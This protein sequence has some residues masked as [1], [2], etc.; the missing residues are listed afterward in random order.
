MNGSQH[1]FDSSTIA[2]APSTISSA[3]ANLNNSADNLCSEMANLM[4]DYEIVSRINVIVMNHYEEMNSDVTKRVLNSI[5][6][7]IQEKDEEIFWVDSC[8]L[9]IVV[10]NMSGN[11]ERFTFQTESPNIKKEWVTELQLVQLV[12]LA[13]DTNNSPAWDVLIRMSLFVKAQTIFKSQHPTEARCGPG[14]SFTQSPLDDVHSTV[15]QQHF[16]IRTKQN[17]IWISSNDDSNTFITILLQNQQQANLLKTCEAFT[18]NKQQ[19]TAVEFVLA[20]ISHEDRYVSITTNTIWLATQSKQ[21]LV[22]LTRVGEKN[23]EMARISESNVV[24]FILFHMNKVFVSLTS[25]QLLFFRNLGADFSGLVNIGAATID[26][27]SFEVI[28]LN[29]EFPIT[30][31]IPIKDNVYAACGKH[32][33]LYSGVSCEL[34]KTHEIPNHNNDATST[35]ST[36]NLMAHSGVGLWISL[37]NSSVICLYHSVTFRHLQDLNIASNVLRV[38]VVKAVRQRLL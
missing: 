12:Q 14:G 13:L 8:C 3:T 21:I 19:V 9:K 28:N 26:L 1:S 22:Y 17:F 32:V 37:K 35:P 38:T 27:N 5:Q 6:W 36:I 24:T 23:R 10:K 11:K 30:S 7:S 34:L 15:R 29:K 4:A 18:L 25:G 31:L 16:K 20:K 33:W 2:T